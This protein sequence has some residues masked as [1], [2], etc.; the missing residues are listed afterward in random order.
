[1]G[2]LNDRFTSSGSTGRFTNIRRPSQPVLAGRVGAKLTRPSLEYTLVKRQRLIDMVDAGIQRPVT[3]ICA[4]AGWG[5][6]VLAASWAE[7]AAERTAAG[8]LTVDAED[9]DPSVFWSHVVAALRATG[10]VPESDLLAG[11]GS[12]A[13]VNKALLRRGA[14]ELAELRGPVVLVLDD[15]QELNEPQVM[16]EFGV[17]LRYQP[18]Q[19]RL[20][21]IDRTEPALPLHRLRA[22]GRI[23]EIRAGDLQF[24]GDEA[25]ELLAACDSRLPS[26]DVATLLG[27]TEG[28]AAGL[29]LAV[30]F[31][32]ASGDGHGTA[33]FAGDVRPVSDYLAGEVLAHLPLEVR[34]FL[35]YTSVVDQVCGEL[36]DMLAGGTHS[37]KI[38]GELERANAFVVGLGSQPR[39]FRYHHLLRDLLRHQLQLE[40]PGMLPQ[41]HLRAARWYF[42]QNATLA[43]L[44]HAVAGED[45]RFVGRLLAARAGPHILSPDRAALV[46]TLEQVPPEELSATAELSLCAALLLFH[47]GDNDAI[48]DQIA[49]ARTLLEGRADADRQSVEIA[50]HGLEVAV[51]RVRGNMPAL[52]T[53]ATDVLGGLHPTPS[54]RIPS[55]LLYRAT[56][57]NDKGVAL[58]W[59]GQPYHADRYLWAA[60]A[61]ARACGVELVEIDAMGHLALFDFLQ[62]ALQ[63]AYEHAVRGRELAERRG[64]SAALQAVPAH[65]AL[66]LVEIERNNITEAQQALRQGLDAHRADPERAQAVVLGLTRVR[67]MMARRELDRAREVLCRTRSDAARLVGAPVFDRWMRLAQSEIDLASGRPEDVK[68]RY[69]RIPDGDRLTARERVCLAR[70]ELAL[71][72]LVAAEAV[73]A[74]LSGSDVVATVEAWIVTALVADTQRQGNRSVDALANAFAIAER[75]GVRRPFLILG[76]RRLTRLMERQRLLIKENA[77]FVADILAETASDDAELEPSALIDDLS[78]REL[79]VLRYLPTMLNAAEIARELHVSFNTVKAHLRS[80]YRKLGAS[81]RRE[82]VVR[83]RGLRIL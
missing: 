77:G 23:A 28:W 61:A 46:K 48:P 3:L 40:A 39:W 30:T 38:L 41:L 11:L 62:G 72:E 34:R 24:N 71:G 13:A 8:W 79:E 32:A 21:L 74:P 60:L 12:G 7:A 9:N 81:R 80:I 55:A 4:G 18:E 57:L 26:E 56:A 22:D 49:Q 68:A 63:E 64:W 75:Q 29:Q 54:A 27:R 20:V 35:L 5:K 42:S 73:L 83:A 82:A 70:A 50:V 2:L 33:E 10:A 1:M 53:A 67:L 58:L 14:E 25:A 69:A 47:A 45:W 37:E 66:A 43:A 17:L 36:A 65:L 31:L 78:E 59:S 51:A 16:A 76:E 52:V 19:L 6:T 15:L 44:R